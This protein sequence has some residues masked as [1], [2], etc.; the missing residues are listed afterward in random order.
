M[1]KINNNTMVK[2]YIFI[3]FYINNTNGTY[4]DEFIEA[5]IISIYINQSE[6]R[7]KNDMLVRYNIKMIAF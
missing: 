6:Q 1:R 3:V 5:M 4:N 7:L 2:S